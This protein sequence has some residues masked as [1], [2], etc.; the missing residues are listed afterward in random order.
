MTAK[1]N[2]R[3]PVLGVHRVVAQGLEALQPSVPHEAAVDEGLLCQIH[4]VVLGR[5]QPLS[6][7]V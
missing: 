4:A 5:G 3:L 6:H 7:Y 1:H 2:A